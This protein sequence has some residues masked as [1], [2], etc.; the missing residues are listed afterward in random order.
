MTF[1]LSSCIATA[2][3]ILGWINMT[4]HLAIFQLFSEISWCFFH[5]INQLLNY[6][7]F[8]LLSLYLYLMIGV[9]LWLSRSRKRETYWSVVTGNELVCLRL[10]VKSQL[11]LFRIGCTML[12][13]KKCWSRSVG[14]GGGCEVCGKIVKC[15]EVCLSTRKFIESS[16]PILGPSGVYT[17]ANIK[18]DECLKKIYVCTRACMYACMQAYTPAYIY[19]WI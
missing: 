11:G 18:I 4:T 5:N 17:T 1:V 16:F 14:L 6:I 3:L 2:T 13:R 15:S 9:M 10:F 8:L 7:Y 12:L 19:T